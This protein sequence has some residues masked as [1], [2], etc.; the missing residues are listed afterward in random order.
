[1]KFSF[2]CQIIDVIVL[3]EQIIQAQ[4]F[5]EMFLKIIIDR[6]DFFSDFVKLGMNDSCQAK[7]S[8]A[9]LLLPVRRNENENRL[10]VD[11][12]LIR[13]CLSSPVFGTGDNVLNV[14]D[15]CSVPAGNCFVLADG[16]VSKSDIVNSLVFTPHN[17][18]FFFVDGILGIDANS[19]FSDE[20]C[21]SYVAHYAQK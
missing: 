14:P 18:L 1:M 19:P 5:Q 13:K 6:E 16:P 15:S 2:S 8:T 7:P 21:L 20:S 17:K 4:N 10:S 3:L 12:K 11:W 9:Y